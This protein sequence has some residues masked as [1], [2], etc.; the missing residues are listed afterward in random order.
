MGSWIPPYPP[1]FRR[2][3]VE[4]VRTSGTSRRAIAADL[5]I[6][7]ETLRQWVKQAELDAGLRQDGLSTDERAELRRLQRENQILRQER[8]IL[9]KAAAFFAK[10]TS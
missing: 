3:A 10:Q 1:E 9:K 5:G 2:E 7:T 4:L 8:A 6:S